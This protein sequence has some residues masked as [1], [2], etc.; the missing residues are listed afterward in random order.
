MC[1]YLSL[2]WTN[3]RTITSPLSRYPEIISSSTLSNGFRLLAFLLFHFSTRAVNI[4]RSPLLLYVCKRQMSRFQLCFFQCYKLD[5]F[6]F[7][8]TPKTEKKLNA[9][10]SSISASVHLDNIWYAFILNSTIYMKL[11]NWNKEE[12]THSNHNNKKKGGESIFFSF[13]HFSKAKKKH[14]SLWLLAY[15][16]ATLPLISLAHALS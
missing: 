5:V 2:T 15:I 7:V 8:F 16:Y 3:K 14:F 13:I 1:V 11:S 9:F 4:F 6:E 10:L 12:A